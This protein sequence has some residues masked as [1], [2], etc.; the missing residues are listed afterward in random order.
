M[1]D[2]AYEQA[3]SKHQ[4]D[5]LEMLNQYSQ[6]DPNQWTRHDLFA[7]QR[8]LQI[9][10]ES[11]IGMAR[12]LVQQKYQ[13]SVSQS[14]EALDELKN[15]ADLN[16]Q[17]YKQLIKIIGF[18]NVL[19]HNYLDINDEIVEA[20]VIQQQ[21]SLLDNFIAQWQEQLTRLPTA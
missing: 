1:R 19:V 21:F 16:P 14:R 8:V 3:L 4:R 5:M 11:F 13:L 10:I 2:I 17:Q 7:I 6:Q 12:Y 20:I 18:R 9:Y 15:R